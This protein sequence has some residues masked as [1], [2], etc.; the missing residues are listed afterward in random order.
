M[1]F[2]THDTANR[3]LPVAAA[4]FNSANTR[5]LT[6]TTRSSNRVS[7]AQQ[8]LFRCSI[9]S[10]ERND[11]CYDAESGRRLLRL[12]GMFMNLHS[13]SPHIADP[14]SMSMQKRWHHQTHSEWR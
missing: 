2:G 5:Q 3:R 11:G 6:G 9:P 14:L 12:D 8:R 4:S 10:G 7:R 1:A 13:T